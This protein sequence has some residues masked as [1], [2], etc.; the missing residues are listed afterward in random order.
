[1]VVIYCINQAVTN[2]EEPLSPFGGR[3]LRWHS[4]QVFKHASKVIRVSASSTWCIFPPQ[5]Y[6]KTDVWE[7]DKI[8]RPPPE[9]KKMKSFSFQY[10]YE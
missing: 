5:I 4:W 7:I 9:S 10:S 2:L 6:L 3:G 1:M 8:H